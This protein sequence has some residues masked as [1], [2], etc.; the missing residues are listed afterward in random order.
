MTAQIETSTAFT[1]VIS[2]MAHE[3]IA[4]VIF[5]ITWAAVNHFVRKKDTS[6]D[7]LAGEASISFAKKKQTPQEIVQVMQSLCSDQFTRALRLYRQLVRTDQDKEIVDEAFYT[8]LVEAAIRVGKA[9]VAEQ[10]VV[11]MHENNMVPSTTFLQSCLKL[12]AARKCFKECI[13]VWKLFDPKPDQVIYSCLTLA[14]SELPDQDLC[15]GFLQLAEKNFTITSRDYVPL[16]RCHARRGDYETAV[17]DVRGLMKRGVEIESILLN[18]TLAVC[19]KAGKG[20]EVLRALIAEMKDYEK[21]FE[22]KCVDTVS[23]NTLIKALAREHDVRGCFA[24]LEEICKS[25]IEADDVTYSTILDVCIDENEN[26]LASEA[27]DK[28]C[29]SGVKMNCVLLTTLMK[30]FIRSKHLD[31]A[32]NLY[33]SMCTQTAQVKPDMITYSMLIKAQCDAGDMGRALQILED[34]LQNSCDIDDV[35]FTHL[36]EGCCQVSNVSLAEKL[37]RDMITAK[38]NPSVYTLT[39]MVKVYGKCHESDKAWE[40]VRDME[41]NFGIKPSC[42]IV[43]CLVSGLLRQKKRAEAY[44]AFKWMEDHCG[45]RPDAHGIQTMVMGLTDAQMFPEI[46]DVIK[47]AL[48]PNR[49]PTVRVSHESLNYALKGALGFK[50]SHQYERTIFKLLVDNK[51]EIT[52]PNVAKRLGFK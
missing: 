19:A 42:V 12:F 38:I 21:G 51:V 50:S 28:M 49:R 9:D 29:A 25:D 32:M 45:V 26:Q 7:K 31:M 35:V 37:Y 11:R 14:A 47:R 44:E 4:L 3:I 40:L 34:M 52:I 48:D 6:S 16:I 41:A 36:I 13:K 17:S 1:T 43:T 33:E 8:A 15:R 18:T 24:M 23:Y 2:S 10:V 46:I 30:G 20:S 5:F 27:L 39:A 22:K